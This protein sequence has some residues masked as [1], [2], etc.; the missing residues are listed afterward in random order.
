MEQCSR[1]HAVICH[2]RGDAPTVGFA[3]ADSAVSRG[4]DNTFCYNR[5]IGWGI[6]STAVLPRHFAGHFFWSFSF[7]TK[8]I[9]TN[10]VN[11]VFNAAD[12]A[13][14]NLASKLFDLGI[15][16][17]ND[18]RPH[19]IK[20]AAE[21]YGAK[22]IKGQRGDTLPQDSAALKAVT[23]V[24]AVIFPSVDIAQPKVS[25]NKVDP[26]KS[27]VTRFGKLSKAEQRRFLASI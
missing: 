17:R 10:A 14:A 5:V 22:I 20:W 26:V 24:L 9:N 25:V 1:H 15:F 21:K 27:L 2:K 13:P 16:T 18:A 7:M 19:A 23:R 12:A 11:A 8:S 3:L 6:A 4:F